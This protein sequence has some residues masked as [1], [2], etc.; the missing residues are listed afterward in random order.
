[1]FV[2]VAKFVSITIRIVHMEH[3]KIQPEAHLEYL[4]DEVE[5]IGY[6]N[7]IYRLLSTEILVWGGRLV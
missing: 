4:I 1:M 5:I 3:L 7:R 2:C 6:Q